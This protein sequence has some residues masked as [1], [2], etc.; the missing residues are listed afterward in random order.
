MT[1]F[2]SVLALAAAQAAG[3]PSP[4]APAFDTSAWTRAA[5]AFR[6]I[7]PVHYVGTE[8]LGVFL[9]TSAKGHVLV[10]GALG[11]SATLIERSIR[12]LGFDPK[13]IKAIVTTQAHCDHVGSMAYFKRAS[14]GQVVAME[15]DVEL[16]RSGGRT[17]Y[18]YGEQAVHPVPQAWFEP[19]VADRT[20][21]DGDTVTVGDLTLTARKTPGHTPG[22]TTWLLGIVEDGRPLTVAFSASTGINPDTRFLDSPSYPGIAEDFKRAFQVLE[23]LSP[24]VPLGSHAG[25]FGLWSKRALQKSGTQPNPFIDPGAFTAHV[26]ERK[27]SFETHLARERAAKGPS[28][29]PD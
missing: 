17:D 21:R 13:D 7:G 27:K 25:F 26:A 8:D 1:H 23:S 24:D 22:S 15:G 18:L 6:V 16:L 14:G 29:R 3:S 9:V 11:E 2:V 12:S 28:P 20:L 4:S 10:D 5:E 19:V